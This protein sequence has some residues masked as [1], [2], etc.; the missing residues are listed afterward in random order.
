MKVLEFFK[1]LACLMLFML[2]LIGFFSTGIG[3]NI[4]VFKTDY[5]I[6]KGFVIFISI[7]FLL[8]AVISFT[9][10]MIVDY[11]CTVKEKLLPKK[12]VLEA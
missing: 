12:N 9:P 6:I 5:V 7:F 2:S 10:F 4:L 8:I 1:D 11:V 3:I